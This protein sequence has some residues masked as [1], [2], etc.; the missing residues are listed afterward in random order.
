LKPEEFPKPLHF[1]PQKSPRVLEP[2]K[3]TI[4]H[5]LAGGKGPYQF[6]LLAAAEGMQLDEKTGML[7]IEPESLLAQG[8]TYL[9]NRYGANRFS[10][11]APV[12]AL[13]NFCFD[14]MAEGTRLIG[15]KPQGV[16][17]AIPIAIRGVDSESQSV[18]FHYYVF[19]EVP[20]ANLVTRLKKLAES[21]PATVITTPLAT[22]IPPQIPAASG[23]DDLKTEVINL[24]R[25]LETMEARLDMLTRELSALRRELNK[26]N[27]DSQPK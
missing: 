8:E 3:T 16:L 4:D 22:G 11:L 21:A 23:S 10:G 12:D 20:Y 18:S 19:A 2:G 6:R 14:T 7:T 24:R 25:K 1:V 9:A 5:R 26:P 13:K 15:R 17:L 27:G